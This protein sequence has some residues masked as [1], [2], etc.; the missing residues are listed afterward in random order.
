MLKMVG[1]SSQNSL[2][3]KYT[4]KHYEVDERGDGS[5]FMV[6]MRVTPVWKRGCIVSY[7]SG[8]QIV[9]GTLKSGSTWP[10]PNGCMTPRR[11][12]TACPACEALRHKTHQ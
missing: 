3:K 5:I 8:W 7:S 11:F 1:S 12:T 6:S 4:G 2:G 10:A 9:A